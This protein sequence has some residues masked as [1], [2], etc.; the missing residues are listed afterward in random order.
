MSL[1]K[2]KFNKNCNIFLYEM[3][4]ALPREVEHDTRKHLTSLVIPFQHR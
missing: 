4:C 2:K 3:F 1:K